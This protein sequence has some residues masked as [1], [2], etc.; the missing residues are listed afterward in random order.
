MPNVEFIKCISWHFQCHKPRAA[1]FQYIKGNIRHLCSRNRPNSA[2]H[3]NPSRWI[4]RT[5]VR[6]K[7]W[8]F[9]LGMNWPLKDGRIAAPD[10][11]LSVWT[12]EQCFTHQTLRHSQHSWCIKL[13]QLINT[14]AYIL[15]MVSREKLWNSS[16]F[17]SHVDI[18]DPLSSRTLSLLVQNHIGAQSRVTCIH[19]N[20]PAC[21]AHLYPATCAL[22]MHRETLQPQTTILGG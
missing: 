19:V 10:V 15:E 4:N 14:C 1:Q 5:K 16:V 6:E 2:T 18:Q 20:G 13:S 8:I 7:I 17:C 3:T 22:Y 11:F 21:V 9:D 12:T